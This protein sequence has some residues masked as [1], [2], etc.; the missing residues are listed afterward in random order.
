[1]GRRSGLI[2]SCSPPR[3]F[4]I[5]LSYI[6]S[7]LQEMRSHIM[8]VAMYRM[9]NIYNT[10][11]YR[12]SR[13]RISDLHRPSHLQNRAG[14]DGK[15]MINALKY[16]SSMKL[17]KMSGGRL[18]NSDAGAGVGAGRKYHYRLTCDW[19]LTRP[20][21]TNLTKSCPTTATM[22]S[23]FLL[24]SAFPVTFQTTSSRLALRTVI[25]G[26]PMKHTQK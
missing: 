15:K 3:R 26:L 22:S 7:R 21:R 24:R 9:L 13:V 14:C 12:N 11:R 5:P 6:L 17:R 18:D 16:L 20:R 23:S 1:V 2:H 8:S 4:T 19:L 10:I 25:Q